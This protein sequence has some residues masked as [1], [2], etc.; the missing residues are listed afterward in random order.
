[1]HYKSRFD[2][3][4]LRSSDVGV[5]ATKLS[6]HNIII[7]DLKRQNRLKVGTDKRK[8]KTKKQSV[9]EIQND[10]VWKRHLESHV[11]NWWQKVYSDWEDVTSS[12]GTSNNSKNIVNSNS[13]SI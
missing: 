12:S 4:S 11:L 10:D 2:S 8:L 7:V 6:H 13:N 5:K 3:V 1:M 9:S